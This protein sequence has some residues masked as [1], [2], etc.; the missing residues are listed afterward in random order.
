MA[1]ALDKALRRAHKHGLKLRGVGIAWFTAESWPRLLE[2]A[3]DRDDLPPNFEAFE[4]RAGERFD[5]HVAN[6]LPLEKVLIDVDALAAWCRE[7][8]MPV[9]NPSRSAFAA[10]TLARRDAG[11]GNA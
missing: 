4:R 6:G 5:R 9:D 10:L 2:I 7:L 3:A 8:G 1:D 11:A